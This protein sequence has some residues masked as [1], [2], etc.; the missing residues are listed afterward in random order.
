MLFLSASALRL[1]SASALTLYHRLGHSFVIALVI[2]LLPLSTL[3]IHGYSLS[4]GLGI[5]LLPVPAAPAQACRPPVVSQF[6]RYQ[7]QAGDSVEAL[8]RRY[9]L[10]AATLLGVNPSLRGGR[11]PV[12]SQI[13]IP[14]FDGVLVRVNAGVRLPE[15]ARTYGIRPDVLFEVNGCQANP[16]VV[17]VPGVL[18]S[19]QGTLR[20]VPQTPTTPAVTG[21]YRYPLAAPGLV[22]TRYGWSTGTATPVPSPSPATLNSAAPNPS[23]FHPGVDI[24]AP[25]QSQ[26][27]A[28]AAGTV[29]FAGPGPDGLSLVVVNHAAGVQTRYSQL[30]KAA[31]TTGQTIPSGTVVGT[32][33][34]GTNERPSHLHFE[35]RL[36]SPKGW[37]AQDPTLYIPSLQ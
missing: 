18:W 32:I 28:I 2:A 14:P 5:S 17:Y 12:G 3:K 6:R 7:V 15:L 27:F 21:R 4:L 11:V 22:L 1:T 16:S 33:A 13:F 34:A 30:A 35:V 29:A 8:S 20:P 10:A 19:P 36:N 23:Q 26:V 31:V 25:A 9:S 24:A 37:I